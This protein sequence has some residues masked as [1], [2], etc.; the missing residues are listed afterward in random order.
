MS[1]SA[2]YS[3]R[4]GSHTLV[5][6][7]LQPNCAIE[8]EEPL[9]ISYPIRKTRESTPTAN[10]IVRCL[11]TKSPTFHWRCFAVERT[12][13]ATGGLLPPSPAGAPYV[14]ATTFCAT[15]YFTSIESILFSHN[16][17]TS[18]GRGA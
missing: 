8:R 7:N 13:E 5:A 10:S 12:D 2:P 4:T 3:S 16:F 11:K 6:R 17:T 1:G 18:F 9:Y 14:C 15:G